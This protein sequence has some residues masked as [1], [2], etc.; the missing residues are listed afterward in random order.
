MTCELVT[1]T[2]NYCIL[3]GE[4]RNKVLGRSGWLL[5]GQKICCTVYKE[6]HC[7]YIAVNMCLT[8]NIFL[9]DSED[10]SDCIHRLKVTFTLGE[11]AELNAE[12]RVV[13]ILYLYFY[14]IFSG[15]ET[16]RNL[17]KAASH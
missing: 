16:S 13:C 12:R 4:T 1:A 14:T 8:V 9:V 11:C 10:T 7:F 17:E 2:E 5:V 3:A 6:D 15:Q